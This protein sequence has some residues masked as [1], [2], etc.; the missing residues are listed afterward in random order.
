MEKSPRNT[1][2][3][4]GD[5]IGGIG[6]AIAVKKFKIN[7]DGSYSGTLV[8]QPDRGHNT[9]SLENF[10]A[11]HQTFDFVLQPCVA[12]TCNSAGNPSITFSYTGGLEY[13]DNSPINEN[14]GLTS[15][16]DAVNIR[17][18]TS[19]FPVLPETTNGALATDMEG[20]A[21]AADGTFWASDEYGPTIYHIAA[22]GTILSAI[23][24]PAAILPHL[25]DGTLYFE[26]EGETP[27]YG[28]VPNQGFEGLTISADN[29]R[30]YGLIQSALSQDQDL[31]L[32]NRQYTR[33]VVY[34]ISVPSTPILVEQYVVTLPESDPTTVFAASEL[35][36]VSA[37]VF[38]ILPRDGKGNGNGNSPSS[39]ATK[40][41]LTSAYKNAALMTT[42]GSTNINGLFDEF[43]SAVA[44]LG[45]LD[46][47]ITP[48]TVQSF[49]NIIDPVQLAKFGLQNGPTPL[50]TD[51][52]GKFESLALQSVLDPAY[53]DDYFLFTMADN[54]FI[55]T[56]EWVDGVN[57]GSDPYLTDVPTQVFVYRVTLPGATVPSYL[58]ASST[59]NPSGLSR[60]RLRRSDCPS[61]LTQCALGGSSFECVD[62]LSSLEQCGG[63]AANGGQD[64]SAIPGVASVECVEGTCVATSCNLSTTLVD[65]VCL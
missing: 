38:L 54:D 36:Y 56:T 62:V 29:T 55:S 12:S 52:V 65:G 61:Y 28:R 51:I 31:T 15:G 60:S 9:V 43:D 49:V 46:P 10:A 1:V 39:T 2:D 63:C 8:A 17:T 25:A 35:H 13:E 11:R 21:L 3:A 20:I 19:N 53:P 16:L 37:G 57:T 50:S 42:V 33:M 23:E 64:C 44:P 22:D 47:S 6:S 58:Q 59:T 32:G 30:L 41:Q 7:S 48:V 14:G 4:F 5:S 45:V 24:P 34:D 40:K 27:T 26:T 18:A